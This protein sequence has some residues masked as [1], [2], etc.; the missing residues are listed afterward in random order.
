MKSTEGLLRELSY[1]VGVIDLGNPDHLHK[2]EQIMLS[3]NLPGHDVRETIARLSEDDIVKN[4]DSGN[5]YV[6]KQHNPDTQS[7]VKKDASDK[8]IAKVKN[9]DTEEPSK[10]K[11]ASDKNIVSGKD[12][13]LKKGDP[14]KT[15]EFQK[16]M[17]PNDDQFI[18]RN[19]QYAIPTPPEPYKAPASLSDNP[20]FPKRYVKA[21][22]RMMNTK[23]TDDTKSWGHF[24]DIEGGAGQ[25]SAQAGE[26]LTMVGSALNEEEFNELMLGLETHEKEQVRNNPDL[27]KEGKRIVT[28]SW[29]KSAR[30][31]RKAIVDRVKRQYGEGAEIIGS[32][33]DAKDEVEALGL[34][35]YDTN[36]GFS[37]DMYLKVKKADG[38]ELLDE[39][40]LKKDKNVNFLNSGTSTMVENWDPEMKGSKIDPKVYARN[41]RERLAKGAEVLPDDIKQSLSKNIE[42]ASLGKGSR[43]NSKAILKA[44]KAEADKGNERAA[45]YLKEDDTIHREMQNEAINQLNT[46]PKMRDG[47]IKEI[48]TEFPLKAV[49]EGEET[50]AIGDMSLDR[51]TMKEIFG[52][53]DF[54]SLKENLTVKKSDKGEPYLAYNVTNSDEEV[55][56]SNIVIRQDGRGYGGGSIKFE[57]KLHPELAKRL[58][59]ATVKVYSND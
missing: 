10:E 24:S 32:S 58:K 33:W 49:S 41:E 23:L 55:R 43:S 6:V 45:A 2:L 9:K 22:E 31:T 53:S 3:A 54:D 48:K 14:G 25:I 46:N 17:E 11:P 5:T 21:I 26:L 4:K 15:Q 56:V 12:K 42:L 20:K 34:S 8:D 44:I 57:M 47:L 39:I 59:E 29:M 38:T 16:D 40:S 1:R 52:T 37:T 19:K 13:T 27:K 50:M 36:K 18:E 35:D 7:L 30:N 28:K 51:E